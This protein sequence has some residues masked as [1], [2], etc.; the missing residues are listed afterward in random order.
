MEKRFY[1]KLSKQNVIKLPLHAQRGIRWKLS[2]LMLQKASHRLFHAPAGR[3]SLFGHNYNMGTLS[4]HIV[5]RCLVL[6][7][8]YYN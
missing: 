5:E 3:G 8:R 7:H 2:T 4:A 6:R 1:L